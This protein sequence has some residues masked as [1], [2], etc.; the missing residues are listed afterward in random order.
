MICPTAGHGRFSVE[1]RQSIMTKGM[2][3]YFKKKI[4]WFVIT[5]IAAVILNFILPRLMPADPV[6]AITGKMASGMTDASAVQEIYKRYEAEF[7]TNKPVI[8]QFFIFVKNRILLKI[9]V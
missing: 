2:R 1:G 8:T 9:K 3:K 7:G 6:S 5:F 4:F